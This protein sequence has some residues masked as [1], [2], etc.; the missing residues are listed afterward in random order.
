MMTN[1]VEKPSASIQATP[2]S[3]GSALTFWLPQIPGLSNKRGVE[4]TLRII[5]QKSGE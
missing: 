2:F 5:T 4:Q 1:V 3:A